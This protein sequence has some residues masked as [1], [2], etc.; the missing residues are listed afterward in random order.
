MYASSAFNYVLMRIITLIALV[1]G[2]YFTLVGAN[3]GPIRFRPPANTFVKPIERINIMIETYPKGFAGFKRLW[4][5]LNR[6]R[7]RPSWCQACTA[8]PRSYWISMELAYDPDVLLFRNWTCPL[9]PERW[10]SRP[11]WGR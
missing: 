5:E 4:Q 10:F 9:R 2:A 1:S 8:L 7:F 3:D 11:K 6:S